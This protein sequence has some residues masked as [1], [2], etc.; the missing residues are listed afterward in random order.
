MSKQNYRLY[1]FAHSWLSGIQKG[2]QTQHATTEL[3]VGPMKKWKAVQ[4]WATED[5]T[6]IVLEGGGTKR[7]EEIMF[8]LA[9]S[10]FPSAHFC[11]DQESLNGSITAVVFVVPEDFWSLEMDNYQEA[12]PEDLWWIFATMK[13][14]QKAY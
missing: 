9:D 11:E 4:L 13:T 2:I 3:L 1:S 8:K 14:A 12:L 5:K 10:P 6:T 7:L